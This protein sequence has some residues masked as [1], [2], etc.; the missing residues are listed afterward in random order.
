MYSTPNILLVTQ[1]DLFDAQIVLIEAR[2]E[3]ILKD[4]PN[5]LNDP[6]L[7]KGLGGVIEELK[8]DIEARLAR[9]TDDNGP[10]TGADLIKKWI[11]L[12]EGKEWC[13]T[14]D[15]EW[16]EKNGVRLSLEQFYGDKT[17]KSEIKSCA[18]RILNDAEHNEWG[19]KRT[20]WM[21]DIV[22]KCKDK[23]A[24]MINLE[25]RGWEQ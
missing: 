7:L 24:R 8:S 11:E 19:H 25:A 2:R 10:E 16:C 18:N 14:E 22:A 6:L 5:I 23:G 4:H 12:H 3:L 17:F 1:S 21:N 15:S 20:V 9:D 13:E